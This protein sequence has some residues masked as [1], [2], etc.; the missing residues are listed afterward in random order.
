[1]ERLLAQDAVQRLIISFNTFEDQLDFNLLHSCIPPGQKFT[2]DLSENLPGTS[3]RQLTADDFWSEVK[4]SIPGFTATHHQLG[5][6]QF[7]FHDETLKKVTART[8][9]TATYSL[10]E[11]NGSVEAVVVKGLQVVDAEEVE[12]RW[13]LR[14]MKVVR[15]VPLENVHLFGVAVE[16]VQKGVGRVLKGRKPLSEGSGPFKK[17]PRKST[18]LKA[19]E[20]EVDYD[21]ERRWTEKEMQ[22]ENNMR[23]L[24]EDGQSRSDKDPHDEYIREQRAERL[25]ADLAV[26]QTRRGLWDAMSA[27]RELADTTKFAK[28]GDDEKLRLILRVTDA[29]DDLWFAEVKAWRLCAFAPLS[30]V[31]LLEKAWNSFCI[32]LKTGLYVPVRLPLVPA[33]AL[34]RWIKSMEYKN[35]GK[36]R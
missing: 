4:S 23:R 25:A 18:T 1:M 19:W 28:A 10:Q 2:L 22:I 17:P 12:G 34:V 14:G 8:N 7:D 6:I 33:V 36:K 16:R 11:E 31:G 30:N 3:A 26:V 24:I 5:P 9:V 13:V 21:Q 27:C 29:M 32:V 35:E 15:G 20:Q